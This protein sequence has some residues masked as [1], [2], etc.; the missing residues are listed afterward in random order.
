MEEALTLTRSEIIAAFV[1]WNAA[2]KAGD[3]E[4]RE[5]AE[6]SADAFIAF[7]RQSD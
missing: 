2:A 4:P 1:R 6:A 3:W 5:D 7:V